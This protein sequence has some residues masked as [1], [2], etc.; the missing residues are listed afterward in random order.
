ML[1]ADMVARGEV[2]PTDTLGD[3]LPGRAFKDPAVGSVTLE[4]LASH[5]SGL[6]R[7][8][9]GRARRAGQLGV[10]QSQRW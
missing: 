3:L 6:P 2:E 7:S 1:F 4:E 8:G 10:G 9:A 5:R